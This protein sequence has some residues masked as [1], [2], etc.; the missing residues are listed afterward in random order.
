MFPVI[1]KF[2]PIT[3]YAYGFMTFIAVV[4]FLN[5]LV[6]QARRLGYDKDLIFDL[7]ITII[8]FGFIGARLLYVLLNLDFYLRN[9]KEILMLTHGGLSILG[10]VFVAI[11]A[12]FIFMKL[13]KLPFLST[14]DLVVPFVALGQS[15]GR[16]GCLLNGC[17]YGFP[18]RI[19][20][21]FYVHDE[22]LFPVQLVSSLLLLILFIV[23]RAKQNR[24]HSIGIIFT[25]YILF[26]SAMRFFIEFIRAD[27]P[28]LLLNLTIFQYLCI[29]LFVFGL[30]L[31]YRIKWRR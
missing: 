3:I 10:G 14:L 12:A 5:L 13:K 2:G 16:F 25:S 17:C 27:S 4:V 9:P 31:S 24:P 19:G 1:F 21:Y 22:V 15:I 26:Y 29:A 8:L 23:L 28:K 11:I 7:G 18:S 6:K 20:F 30:I